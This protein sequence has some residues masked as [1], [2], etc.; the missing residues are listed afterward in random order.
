[1]YGV[2]AEFFLGYFANDRIAKL[3]Y[4][5]HGYAGFGSYEV[6][7]LHPILPAVQTLSMGQS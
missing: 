5:N 4:N 3:H 1:M 6:Q 2:V 7:P